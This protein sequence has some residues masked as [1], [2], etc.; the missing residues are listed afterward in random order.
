MQGLA[1][2]ALAES[3]SLELLSGCFGRFLTICSFS[4]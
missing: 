2:P 1:Y 4:R 3:Q